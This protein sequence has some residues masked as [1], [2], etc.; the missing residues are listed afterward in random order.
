[1]EYGFHKRDRNCGGQYPEGTWAQSGFDVG[2]IKINQ[3]PKTFISDQVRQIIDN[4]DTE[5]L[6][7]EKPRPADVENRKIELWKL[8]DYERERIQ[9]ARD[10][11]RKLKEHGRL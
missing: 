1:M 2:P 4:A 3:C 10:N 11:A 5:R 8:L 9:R 6:Y 7:F